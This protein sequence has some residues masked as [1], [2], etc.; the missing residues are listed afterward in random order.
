MFMYNVHVGTVIEARRARLCDYQLDQFRKCRVCQAIY[1]SWFTARDNIQTAQETIIIK[2]S[3][4]LDKVSC[5]SWE[6]KFLAGNQL[7]EL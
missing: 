1:K 2:R 7:Y 4:N 5:L 6:L 3:G